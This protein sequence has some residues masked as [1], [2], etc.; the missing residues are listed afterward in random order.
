[1]RLVCV[2]CFCGL[3]LEQRE[4]ESSKC[5]KCCRVSQCWWG[6]KMWKRL[7]LLVFVASDQIRSHDLFK[8]F[9]WF[10]YFPRSTAISRNLQDESCDQVHSILWFGAWRYPA[11]SSEGFGAMTEGVELVWSLEDD[12][13]PVDQFNGLRWSEWE[14]SIEVRT[15]ASR[16][17][18]SKQGFFFFT[19]Q[20]VR[21]RC[22]M[23]AKS[24]GVDERR[25]RVDQNP[26][27]WKSHPATSQVYDIMWCAGRGRNKSRD[28][29]VYP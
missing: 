20:T 7:L 11:M 6:W 16:Y 23:I 8:D 19:W 29:E 24:W 18:P 14:I 28:I 22:R 1:M 26:E 17:L 12:D 9:T 10:I 13:F 2:L 21:M 3:T 27:R 15:A 5:R 25:W 4:V